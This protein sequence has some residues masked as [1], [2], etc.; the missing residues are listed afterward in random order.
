[1]LFRKIIALL[2]LV[3]FATHTFNRA[4]IVF[5]FY[6]N[7]EVIAATLCENK[8]KPVMKCEGKCQLSKKLKL[9]E[10][11]EQQNPTQ[12]VEN[13]PQD[14]SSRSFFTSLAIT[15]ISNAEQWQKSRD[16]G[17][18]IHRSFAVF[19]PPITPVHFA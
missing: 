1:M 10:K 17:K 3:A 2:L 14:I 4:V 7:Q 19:H 16:S 5:G 13:K 9:Q 18:P 12:K 6:A 15:T 11:K 8:D